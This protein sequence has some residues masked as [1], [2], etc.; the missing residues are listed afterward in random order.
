M[1]QPSC[2]PCAAPDRT[3]PACRSFAANADAGAEILI[4]G[5]MPGAESLRQ[6]RYYAFRHNFFWPIMGELF[7]FPPD[8]PYAE[9]LAIL[10][11]HRIAL[12]DVFAACDREGSLD[13]AIRNGVPND[14]PG[15]LKR[16]PRIR[17]ICCNGQT[18]GKS[19]RRFFPELAPMTVILPST[20]PA[21]AGIPP[22][23]RRAR[24]REALTGEAR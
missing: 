10:R 15:L 13:A 20:S 4:L 16:C 5:S 17:K 2:R 14:I 12:W 21:A 22:E 3:F 7:G 23:V 24:W 19:L 9:R 6:Q 1:K 11:S 18:A 8:A